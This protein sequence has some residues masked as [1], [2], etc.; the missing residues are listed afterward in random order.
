MDGYRSLEDSETVRLG[1][2]AFCDDG[3]L[4]IDSGTYHQLLVGC[5][6]L[7]AREFSGVF[8]VIRAVNSSD[9]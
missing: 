5:T 7:E 3:Y 8:G 6:A 1:D 2:V 9:N 4:V